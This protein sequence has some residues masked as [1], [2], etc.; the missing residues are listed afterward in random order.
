MDQQQQEMP[1]LERLWADGYGS[2][3]TETVVIGEQGFLR[4]V[5]TWRLCLYRRERAY[6]TDIVLT[7]FGPYACT[8][9]AACQC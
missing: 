4:P 6:V 2:R 1:V 7:N 3:V 8:K 9:A 5:V